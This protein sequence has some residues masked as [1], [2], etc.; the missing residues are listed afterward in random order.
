MNSSLKTHLQEVSIINTSKQRVKL[1]K[2]VFILTLSVFIL[3][4]CCSQKTRL[5][6]GTSPIVTDKG[7][8]IYIESA[9]DSNMVLS[10][11]KKNADDAVVGS[12]L[13][14]RERDGS[15]AQLW[16]SSPTYLYSAEGTTTTMKKNKSITLESARKIDM[17]ID[18]AGSGTDLNLTL[19][20]K[21]AKESQAWSVRASCTS[22]DIWILS[23]FT[24]NSFAL[25]VDAT[26]TALTETHSPI[27]GSYNKIK[28]NG[29]EQMHVRF[30]S[31][32]ARDVPITTV[33]H[34]IVQEK[35][36][37]ISSRLTNE[38][39]LVVH[40]DKD[41][42]VERSNVVLSN[43][44]GFRK[45]EYWKTI[46]AG[47]G[48]FYFES[49]LE[50]GK[51]L[52]RSS[53]LIDGSSN[54]R[55]ANLNNEP[56]QKWKP[57]LIETK[58]W[59]GQTQEVES[60]IIL[61]NGK[62]EMVLDVAGNETSDGTNVQVKQYV[63]SSGQ[64]FKFTDSTELVE[65]EIE[66]ER[67]ANILVIDTSKVYVIRVKHS[68][69]AL[70][71]REGVYQ[72]DMHGGT[73]QQWKFSYAGNQEYYIKNVSANKYMSIDNASNLVGAKVLLKEKTGGREQRFELLYQD[74][75]WRIKNVDSGLSL[76]VLGGIAQ[77]DNEQPIVQNRGHGTD[78][79]RF[80]IFPAKDVEF[81]KERDPQITFFNEAGYVARY[82]IY[83]NGKLRH[84]TSDVSLGFKKS[85]TVPARALN[86]EIVGKASTLDDWK[87]IFDKN[88]ILYGEDYCIKTF[89]TVFSPEYNNDCERWN[90]FADS[91]VN[92]TNLSGE[93]IYVGWS[94]EPIWG[95]TNMTAGILTG[96]IID[97]TQNFN[98]SY[99]KLIAVAA[100]TDTELP[101]EAYKLFQKASIKI[102]NDNTETVLEH[103]PLGTLLNFID[104]W[105]GAKEFAAKLILE[106][107]EQTD[108]YKAKNINYNP[109][110]AIGDAVGA[111]TKTIM[112]V[113]Q[114][115][116]KFWIVDTSIDDSWIITPA[117]IYKAKHGTLR[118]K[119][120]TDPRT[121]PNVAPKI[122]N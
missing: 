43:S 56:N 60:F 50:K 1:G 78:S 18:I 95:L 58:K 16:K 88:I 111:E 57:R 66:K 89:G 55:L 2:Y 51:V 9:I 24:H 92:V 120:K 20:R 109:I 33:K 47:D 36:Y 17:V 26:K 10:I 7:S 85:F 25:M 110:I 63:G 94:N 70:D 6:F 31:A 91:E 45:S 54:V 46:N 4:G 75:N 116:T 42:L 104:V 87:T 12:N 80:E 49:L 38:P 64:R 90:P 117:E 113:N 93:K 102:E 84:E 99:Y 52:E 67:I 97:Q 3:S 103:S 74:T 69:K 112:A 30:V 118:Q 68:G 65:E 59:V 14:W 122:S 15:N 108:E 115:L 22:D 79:Q 34:N 62:D 39:N 5:T 76:D 101:R 32:K 107:A 53:D 114:S 61:V 44:E 96:L 48:F 77:L 119:D 72:W 27:F 8:Y 73:I 105:T 13:V 29:R 98:A 11:E 35:F 100:A 83:Y 82:Y 40:V 81:Y 19:Q 106:T 21:E 28:K 37:K 86:L 23:P 41:L 121:K 71:C